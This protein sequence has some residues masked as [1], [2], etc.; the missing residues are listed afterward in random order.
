[1]DVK[2]G[3]SPCL[4][5]PRMNVSTPTDQADSQEN[6]NMQSAI[7]LHDRL[8]VQIPSYPINSEIG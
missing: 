7:S 2:T 6:I 1:M 5:P 8:N 3:H 4:G